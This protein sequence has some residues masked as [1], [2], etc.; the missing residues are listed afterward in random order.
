LLFEVRGAEQPGFLSAYA[1]PADDNHAQERV[2]YFGG[3]SESPVIT[4]GAGPEIVKRVVRLGN[5]HAP[6]RYR[7][8]ILLSARALSREEALRP[9][10]PSVIADRTLTFTVSP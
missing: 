2:W 5:E 4:G 1:E 6:G 10:P 3:G 9:D 8:R 7:L